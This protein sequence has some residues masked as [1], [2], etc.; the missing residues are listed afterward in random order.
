MRLNIKFRFSPK[1]MFLSRG[2]AHDM[3]TRNEEI[4]SNRNKFSIQGHNILLFSPA[5]DTW[6]SLVIVIKAHYKRKHSDC[7]FCSDCLI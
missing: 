7:T 6:D 3:Q 1:V 2:S 4:T 5:C